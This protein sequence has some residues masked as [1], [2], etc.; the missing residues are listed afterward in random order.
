MLTI[1]IKFL[2]EITLGTPL[3]VK[4]IASFISGIKYTMFSENIYAINMSKYTL[5]YTLNRTI[6]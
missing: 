4:V 2:Q 6:T 5:Q 1:F 3:A